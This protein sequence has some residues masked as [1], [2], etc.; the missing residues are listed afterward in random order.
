M[1]MPIML[2]AAMMT[3]TTACSSEDPLNYDYGNVDNG[4]NNDGD[5]DDNNGGSSSGSYSEMKTFT[6]RACEQCRRHLS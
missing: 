6:G 2:M 4:D 1:M 3:M 5:G